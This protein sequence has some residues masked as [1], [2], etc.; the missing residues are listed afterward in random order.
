MIFSVLQWWALC[1]SV[2]LIVLEPVKGFHAVGIPSTC[3]MRRHHFRRDDGQREPVIDNLKP[4]QSANTCGDLAL[5]S[6]K[7]G[8]SAETTSCLNDR[9]QCL[10]SAAVFVSAAVAL[11][12]ASGPSRAL[13]PEQASKDY[14]TYSSTYNDL[15]GGDASTILGID[16][17]RSAL[18]QQARGAVLEIG[19]GT[20]LNLNKYCP[21]QLTS[22]TLVDISEGMLQEAQKR[23]QATPSLKGVPVTFIKADATSSELVD[24]FGPQAFDT[25]VD[26][27]SLCVMGNEGAAKCLDQ[28]SKVV[29]SKSNG[30]KKAI[31]IGL[32]SIIYIY[33]LRHRQWLGVYVLFR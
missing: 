4:I 26:S 6:H 29:K 25:V 12:S 33:Y 13:S 3:W 11:T 7:M 1:S 15:D 21:S 5:F 27:F 19:A 20:G 31:C 10:T 24:R 8:D 22:L 32:A 28:L 2:L 17:A 16:Q 23:I 30:G 9:R 14:D 18:F